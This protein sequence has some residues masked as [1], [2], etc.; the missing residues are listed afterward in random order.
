MNPL[1]PLI[2]CD[3]NIP[4]ADEVFSG[5]GT[6]RTVSGRDLKKNNL[7][8]AEILLVR[9]VTKVDES[10]L[11]G[12]NIKIVA[13]A[14]IGTDHMDTRWLDEN[15]IAWT[16]APG[17]NAVS[18][19][20][21]VVAILAFMRKKKNFEQ[22]KPRAGIIGLGNVGTEVAKRL[23]GLG[24]EVLKNDPPKAE[25]EQG[26]HS[27]PL[28]DFTDLDLICLHTPLTRSGKHPTFHLIDHDFLARQKKGTLLISAGRGP[29]IDF[30]AIPNNT[31]IS[32]ALD[33][34]EPE[35]DISLPI[36]KQ[37][38][39]ATPH[40]AGYSLQSK[41]RGLLMCY[42]FIKK[43]THVQTPFIFEPPI[44][45][46]EINLGQK[47]LTWEDVVLKI[48]DPLED[49]KHTKSALLQNANVAQAFDQ[50]RK[51]YPL[52]HEFDFPLLKGGLFSNNDKKTLI[53]LGFRF[54]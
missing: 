42:D 17:C 9:S 24:F 52:R 37:A 39:F 48:Y 22:N 28:T 53:S 30:S 35:P 44:P 27:T 3:E 46:P 51:K 43:H 49:T 33:V 4:L 45:P 21:Y 23:T 1:K 34:W 2:I 25:I 12:T 26:F 5:L 31:H 7:E 10:L 13:T 38:D 41:W 6:V 18:V 36:L 54:S 50:L 11:S 40:V 14:T 16:A 47:N 32:Y 15:G 29:A 19:A 20:E 8:G